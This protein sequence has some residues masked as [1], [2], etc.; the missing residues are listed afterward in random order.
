MLLLL[1]TRPGFAPAWLRAGG[2]ETDRRSKV[3]SASDV[4]AT[5]SRALLGAS[6]VSEPLLE[7]LLDQSERQ[8][9][10]PGGDRA[11]AAGD[12]RHRVED[13][14]ARSTPADVSVPETIHDII[15]ARVDR[16]QETLKHT[17]Q[18]AAVVGREFGV[19]ARLAHPGADGELATG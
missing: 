4:A 14:A 19:A 2:A 5:W 17:L 10:L 8:S 1:T 18:A 9:P 16:L 12:R 15:A 7:I 13:G 11:P 6:E 3:S